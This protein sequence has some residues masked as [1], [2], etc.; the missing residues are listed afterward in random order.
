[1]PEKGA[2][3]SH[4]F[5][6]HVFDQKRGEVTKTLYKLIKQ[7]PSIFLSIWL[8]L[9]LAQMFKWL[10]KPTQQRIGIKVWNRFRKSP[11]FLE[12]F[13]SLILII[14]N[15]KTKQ[16]EKEANYRINLITNCHLPPLT[17]NHWANFPFSTTPAG[18]H[19]QPHI[20]HNCRKPQSEINSTKRSLK[21]ITI[22]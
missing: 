9:M 19:Q 5:L 11:P 8:N 15:N 12:A 7:Q 1:M 21:L 13:L 14:T 2:K 18:Q 6:V 20:H 10:V 4:W 16:T 22:T 17:T 3:I